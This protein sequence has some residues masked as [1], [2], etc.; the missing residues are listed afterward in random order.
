M[1]VAQVRIEGAA[2]VTRDPALQGYGVSL[3]W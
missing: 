2:L 1:L 3:I